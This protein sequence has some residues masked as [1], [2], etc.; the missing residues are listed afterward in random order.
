MSNI[1]VAYFGHPGSFSFK[2]AKKFI[3]QIGRKA[4]L[5]PCESIEEVLD[6][7]NIGESYGVVPT[8]NSTTGKVENYLKLIDSRSVSEIDDISLEVH[9]CLMALRKIDDS[10]I[11]KIYSHP[12]AFKQC[13]TYLKTRF[14]RARQIAYSSTST[15]AYD[16]AA[17]ILDADAAVIA[18][19]EA[20]KIY[21]LK[22]LD[23]GIQDDKD[24]TTHFK[25]L[26]KAD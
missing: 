23:S 15:A 24:N 16:L 1:K 2:A 14:P 3:S 19:E 25:V 21:N 17:G 12:Q 20:A 7:V 18:S 6:Y 22:V 9:H 8:Y 5:Y 26:F 10:K 4:Y 11:K 13:S